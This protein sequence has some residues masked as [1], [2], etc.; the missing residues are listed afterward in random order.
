[1]AAIRPDDLPAAGIIPTTTALIIDTGSAVVKATPLQIVDVAAPVASSIDAA[2][3]TDNTKRMTALRVKEAIDARPALES[4]AGLAALKAADTGQPKEFDQVIFTFTPGNYTGQADDINIVKS[5]FFAL[6]TG[7][8]VRQGA[9]KVNYDGRSVSEKV[10]EITS[11]ADRQFAGGAVGDA[12]TDNEAALIAAFGPLGSGLRMVPDGIYSTAQVDVGLNVGQP[13]QIDGNSPQVSVFRKIAADSD[14]ILSLTGSPTNLDNHTFIS[15]VSFDNALRLTQDGS[16]I[17]FTNTARA[18]TQNLIYDGLG[19]GLHNKG[20]LLQ[21]HINTLFRGGATGY[22]SERGPVFNG[23]SYI[24][25]NAVNFI[26][27]GALGLTTWGHDVNQASGFGL[28]YHNVEGCGD[29]ESFET[30][31]ILFRSQLSQETGFSLASVIG[32]HIERCKGGGGIVGSGLTGATIAVIATDLV[33][34]SAGRDITLSG[35]RSFTAIGNN[36]NGETNVQSRL[37]AIVGGS[38]SS[39]VDTSDDF[40]HHCE[41][42]DGKRV[43]WSSQRRLVHDLANPTANDLL[44]AKASIITGGSANDTYHYKY[45]AGSNVFGGPGGDRFAHG[46]GGIAFF[47]KALAAAEAAPAAATDAASALTLVNQI[48]T[49]MIALGLW[50]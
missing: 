3:G 16:G 50:T 24:Y 22:K 25:P 5:D 28:L 10:A 39:I 13:F 26:G 30:G 17:V 37:S 15:N 9:D 32:C 8:W 38:Y 35:L 33:S 36:G 31:G 48:R 40:F 7:A 11:L 6:S 1:M 46:S 41:T 29:D 42:S 21:T 18:G 27:G 43:A 23:S 34:N 12:A 45:G 44:T 49:R 19:V 14:A 4:A 47:G 20:A 2:A